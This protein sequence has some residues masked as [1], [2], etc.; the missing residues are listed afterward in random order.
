MYQDGLEFIVEYCE[1]H[2]DLVRAR[3]ASEHCNSNNNFTTVEFD[4]N[5]NEEPITGSYCTCTAGA[6]EVD[7]C[8]QVIAVM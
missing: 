3:F 5:L 1:N 6:L 2:F 4:C 7:C 8:A